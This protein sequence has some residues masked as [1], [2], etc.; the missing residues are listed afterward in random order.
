MN[1]NNSSST[2]D[3]EESI[4][5]T[6]TAMAALID[7]DVLR[8]PFTDDEVILAPKSR[9]DDC[10]YIARDLPALGVESH[11]GPSLREYL[12][13]EMID[14]LQNCNDP[15]DH[16]YY[17]GR[18]LE[19]PLGRMAKLLGQCLCAVPNH[20]RG[21]RFT[22]FRDLLIAAG[23]IDK[24]QEILADHRR[25]EAAEMSATPGGVPDGSPEEKMSRR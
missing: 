6:L 14:R 7:C 5:A 10:P 8:S 25:K 15:A 13:S 17:G 9:K 20:E 2:T 4:L 3:T 11:V 19:F 21:R 1:S 22:Q 18:L 12:R 16:H 24:V 23:G